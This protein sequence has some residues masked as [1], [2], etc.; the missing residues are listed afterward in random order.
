MND[1]LKQRLVGAL[2]LIALGVVFWPVVFVETERAGVDRSSQLEPMPQLDDVVVPEPEPLADVE[3]VSAADRIARS[4]PAG[5]PA[6]SEPAPAADENADIDS[7]VK[8]APESGPGRR[9][10][11][12][13][14]IAV[15]PSPKAKPEPKPTRKPTPKPTPKPAA[16]SEPADIP[17]SP[18]LDENGLPI[19]NFVRQALATVVAK[20]N[21]NTM[22]VRRCQVL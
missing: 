1:I 2:V 6:A 11:T 16:E 3:P 9:E 5:G 7:A 13:T 18:A 4:E 21:K 19:L 20:H 22:N 10:E 15:A 14:A 8:V 12:G 17:A